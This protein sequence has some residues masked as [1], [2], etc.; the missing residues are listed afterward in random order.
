[1]KVSQLGMLGIPGIILSLSPSAC[2]E[3]PERFPPG[4]DCSAADGY[5]FDTTVIPDCDW[6]G[7]PDRTGAVDC[8]HSSAGEPI[9][10]TVT[11]LDAVEQPAGGAGGESP[12][13]EISVE[14][15]TGLCEGPRYS[16]AETTCET[17]PG[18]PVCPTGGDEDDEETSS[19]LHLTG[20]RNNDWGGFFGR[21]PTLPDIMLDRL[22][23]SESGYGYMTQDVSEW[24]GIAFWARAEVGA[25]RSFT[26][27][28]DDK[29]TAN[30]DMTAQREELLLEHFPEHP[31]LEVACVVE[32]QQQQ[33]ENTNTTGVAQSSGQ[34]AGWVPSED[35]CG[36]PYQY[37]VTVSEHWELY[38]LPFA[39]FSQEP[40]PNRRPEGFDRTT[41]RGIRIRAPK[42]TIVDL[43]LQQIG[44]YRP[45]K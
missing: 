42:D 18:G 28:L 15:P 11:Y 23:T 29:H 5:E 26:V 21:Y 27:E 37:H 6:F 2:T 30:A 3:F 25:E 40:L 16:R 34:I 17:L 31:D 1:M 39:D 36:N 32:E 7:V 9:A 20:S 14:V 4:P 45:L 44:V 19:A 41:L 13:R 12:A 24:E 10:D 35:G 22:P 33:A 8:E 43:W 38:L